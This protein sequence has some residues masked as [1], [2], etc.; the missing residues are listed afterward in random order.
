MDR[1]D[2]RNAVDAAMTAELSAAVDLLEHDDELWVGV[3]TGGP[4]VLSAGTD[5]IAGAG[6]STERGGPYGVVRRTR[7]KPLDVAREL[8]TGVRLSAERAER[9]RVSSTFSPTRARRPRRPSRWPSASAQGADLGPRQSDRDGGDD[10]GRRRAGDQ[11]RVGLGGHRGREACAGVA[12]ALGL[13][14]GPA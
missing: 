1:A 6:E 3:L 4:G 10:R 11:D 2:K 8:L 13:R 14:A 12:G 7:S 5:L 9:P